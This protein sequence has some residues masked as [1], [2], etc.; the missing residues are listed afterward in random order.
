[1]N[2]VSRTAFYC[3]GVRALDARQPAPLCGDRYAERFMDDEAWRLFAPFRRFQ[4]PNGSNVVRHR[5]IDDLL[6]ARLVARPQLRVVLVGAGFDARAYRLGGGRWVEVDETPLL[7]F[8]E[9]RLPAAECPNPLQ[10]IAIDFASESLADKLAPFAAQDRESP[11]VAVVE[12]VLMYLSEAQIRTLAATLRDLFPD[13]E[14]V[15]DVATKLFFERY[16]RRL[17]ARIRDLGTSFTLPDR[18][19][20][21]I[22]ADEGFVQLS[23][24]SIPACAADLKAMPFPARLAA[25]LLPS[26]RDGYTI[27][28][29]RRSGLE[30]PVS[31][32][33]AST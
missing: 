17:H 30:K 10:R 7:A 9:P 15:C 14:I 24:E 16:G 3:A 31:S 8:K 11:A 18:P 21:A 28:V 20:E 2:P 19:L 13:L 22:L 4:A 25:R 1:M 26:L 6:R 27:R 33:E 23:S 32:T 5:M 29:F 12:G